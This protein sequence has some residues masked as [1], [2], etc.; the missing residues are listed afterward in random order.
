MT[1]T[2][3]TACHRQYPSEAAFCPFCGSEAPPRVNPR[4]I[5]AFTPTAEVAIPRH[6]STIARRLLIVGAVVAVLATIAAA[7]FVGEILR[8]HVGAGD[9]FAATTPEGATEPTDE[10][11][12]P[13]ILAVRDAPGGFD[14]VHGDELMHQIRTADGSRY[15]SLRERRRAIT[16]RLDHVAD[17][18]EG[19]FEA[20]AAGEHYEIVWSDGA[21]SFRVFDVTRADAVVYGSEAVD[22]VANL[23]ADRMNAAI[24]RQPPSPVGQTSSPSDAIAS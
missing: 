9:S 8:E 1:D 21:T 12:L 20:R 13:P 3:C 11:P 6:E 4:A 5:V 2:F 17:K 15:A 7:A 19:A 18:T 23:A 24:G 16:V 14:I 10:R 22:L